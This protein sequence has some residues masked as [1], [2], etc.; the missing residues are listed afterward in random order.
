VQEET[1]SK[2]I[3][4]RY[5]PQVSWYDQKARQNRSSWICFQVVTICLAV[6]V[7]VLI[8]IGASWAHWPAVTMSAL[9]AALTAIA[10]TLKLEENWH[11]YRG[12]CEALK[13]EKHLYLTRIGDYAAC[14]DPEE[15][16]VERVE[17]L[18]SQENAAWV[19]IHRHK[20]H[21]DDK[22][23]STSTTTLP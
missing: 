1:L 10:R 15:L 4:D 14:D 3:E 11:N 23:A 16:F 13:R 2:Y 20:K 6:A 21:H 22:G 18:I 19:A 9:L 12:T 5:G 17:S 7:P 8:T